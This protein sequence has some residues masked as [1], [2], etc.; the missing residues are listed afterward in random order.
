M[1]HNLQLLGGDDASRA[2]VAALLT[3]L[4][5]P[6][7]P[8][9]GDATDAVVVIDARRDPAAGLDLLRGCKSRTVAPPVLLLAG[10]GPRPEPHLA[11]AAGADCFVAEP[12]EPAE[13]RD[14]VRRLAGD[15]TASA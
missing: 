8:P 6:L 15:A 1:A 10:A 7:L 14:F 4:D 5:L 11:W 13:L 2:G 9:D 12:F 3:P